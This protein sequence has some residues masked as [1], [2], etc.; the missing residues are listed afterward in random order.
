MKKFLLL[1]VVFIAALFGICGWFIATAEMPT[2]QVQR[3]DI[4]LPS[5][6]RAKLLLQ[7][8]VSNKLRIPVNYFQV[9]YQVAVKNI[10]LVQG[11]LQLQGRI[12]AN[13][14]AI[15][16]LPLTVDL[17]KLRQI[18]ME[19]RDDEIPLTVSGQLH[20]DIKVKKFILPFSISRQVRR[21]K[22]DIDS[23]I[24][25]CELQ[26]D[27]QR[28][29]SINLVLGISNPFSHPLLSAHS[30]YQIFLAGR[31]VISGSLIC[32]EKI[33]PHRQGRLQLPIRVDL[34]KLR[35]GRQQSSGGKLRISGKLSAL[36]EQ[37]QIE[38]PFNI[39][40]TMPT[41]PRRIDCQIQSIAVA[42]KNGIMLVKARLLLQGE[43]PAKLRLGKADYQAS[44][45]GQPV[46]R[47]QVVVTPCQQNSA[48]Y[49]VKVPIAIKLK[50]LRQIKQQNRGQPSQLQVT[51][52][53]AL[54]L[55]E[56]QLQLPFRFSKP[57]PARGNKA[58]KCQILDLLIRQQGE[59]MQMVLLVALIGKFPPK[60]KTLRARY[61]VKMAGQPIASGL[62]R[63]DQARRTP[64]KMLAQLP[65][66]VDIV[67]LRQ[68]K[69]KYI[70][71]SVTLELQGIVRLELQDRQLDLPFSFTKTTELRGKAFEVRVRAVQFSKLTPQEISMTLK[72]AIQSKVAK[73]INGLLANYRVSA[74]GKQ[75]IS[76]QLK[77]AKLAPLGTGN[78]EVPLTVQTK[79]LKAIKKEN[80]GKKTPVRIVGDISAMVNGRQFQTPFSIEKQVELIEKPF[81]LKLKKIRFRK[82]RF[83]QRTYLL[84]VEVTNNTSRKIENLQIEGKIVLGKGIEVEMLDKNITL[85]PQQSKLLNLEMEAQ[86]FALIKL[87][88]QVIRSKITRGRWRMKFRGKAADGVEIASESEAE[89][90]VAVEK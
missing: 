62:A 16:Q 1:L 14:K 55:P 21:Q 59:Q 69:Q 82:W 35:Q 77:V 39:E 49:Q 24:I 57:L 28:Q 84:V 81:A 33:L 68:L 85:L 29:L 86:R 11:K 22:R 64:G 36:L 8:E 48:E 67:T 5:P 15:L 51:G 56:R 66:T 58:I 43:L 19:M 53:L 47:G 70:G 4:Q 61:Q 34:A 89:G 17:A 41:Q 63:L 42:E 31:P 25:S 26:I 6:D 32:K 10:E 12:G 90:E 38:I 18:K 2:V 13:D 75:I 7:A 20:L 80:A 27:E 78:A 9:D 37:R 88:G 83:R 79:Q 44:I 76:G 23:R 46:A 65:V 50:R 45:A 60:I 73:E 72:L 30:Q 71:Q 3:F 54:V 74:Q 40:K 87:L 52:K